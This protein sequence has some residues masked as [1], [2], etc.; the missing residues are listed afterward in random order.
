[1]FERLTERIQDAVKSLKGQ[2][3]ITEENIQESLRS[4]RMALL[5]ADVH[6]SVVKDF[7]EGVKAKALGQEVLRSLSPD[8]HFVKI[9]NDEMVRVL[10]EGDPRLRFPPFGPGIILLAGL[11]GSGKTTTAGKLAKFFAKD[12]H[13]VM[14]VP[15][16]VYRP[17]AR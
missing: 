15:A 6:V 4:V 1:M 7:L 5:E 12:G 17:A 10:G 8:Q 14:L 2:G 16:D 3:K 13:P 11:Q 9:L